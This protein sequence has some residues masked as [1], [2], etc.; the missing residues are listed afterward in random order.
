MEYR[1]DKTYWRKRLLDGENPKDFDII[2][3]R[4][5]YGNV[6]TIDV[7]FRGIAFTNPKWCIPENGEILNGDTIVIK[8]GK[9]WSITQSLELTEKDCAVSDRPE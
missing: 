1:E 2:R 5:G 3:F 6:P 4:N 9:V 7:Q 8:L